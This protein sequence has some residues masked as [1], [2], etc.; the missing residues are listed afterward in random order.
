[1]SFEYDEIKSSFKIIDYVK[2]SYITIKY[3]GNNYTVKTDYILN[4]NLGKIVGKRAN[5]FKYKVGEIVECETALYK[6][7][8]M[9]KVIKTYSNGKSDT[10]RY[11]DCIC[12]NCGSKVRKAER[13]FTRRSGCPICGKRRT[14]VVCGVNSLMD[15]APEIIKFLANEEDAFTNFKSSS[16]KVSVKCPHCGRCLKKKYT[17]NYIYETLSVPCICGDGMSK[18]EKIFFN[19]LEQSNIEFEYQYSPE[20]AGNYRYDFFIEQ[21]NIV[22]EVDG[23]QHYKESN[24]FIN[25]LEE[26][27]KNDET[28]TFLCKSNGLS[29]KRINC[30]NINVENIINQIKNDVELNFINTEKINIKDCKKY[31]VSNRVKEVCLYVNKQEK[32][33]ISDI[34]RKFKISEKTILSYLK[35]GGEVDWCDFK[36]IENIIK[37]SKLP[38]FKL[39]IDGSMVLEYKGLQTDFLEKINK[40][41]NIKISRKTM[42]KSITDGVVV[43]GNLL[44]TKEV[45]YER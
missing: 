14:K 8:K 18:P 1:M 33:N 32:I 42:V 38:N 36:N 3:N 19:I 37:Q 34:S 45:Q 29:I 41:M 15:E 31:S 11:Y 35:K 21:Y 17:L 20:W 6:V 22:I 13:D 7:V 44:F 24:K 2:K 39:Y 4:C 27:I 40:E 23:E 28:K 43:K 16:K 10:T 25:T 26:T 5:L 30:S 12:L 9:E